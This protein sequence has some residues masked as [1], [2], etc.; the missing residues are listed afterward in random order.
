MEKC[1][2]WFTVVYCNIYTSTVHCKVNGKYFFTGVPVSTVYN[3]CFKKIWTNHSSDIGF[4]WNRRYLQ[5]SQKIVIENY[6][7]L[8]TSKLVFQYWT[9]PPLHTYTTSPMFGTEGEVKLSKGWS[10][11]FQGFSHSE[12]KILKIVKKSKTNHFTIISKNF[13]IR[14]FTWL[15]ASCVWGFWR[16]HRTIT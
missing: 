2:H 14:C 8:K 9:P 13:N 10:I 3:I 5:C 6:P 11:K 4:F 1:K 12:L 15:Y 7:V 16:L